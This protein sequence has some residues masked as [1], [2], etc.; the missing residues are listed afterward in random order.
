LTVG[1]ITT[2]L[3][4]GVASGSVISQN[5]TA[6]TQV[7]PGTSVALV[8]SL[9]SPVSVPNT[10]NLTQTAAT[11]AIT[12]AHLVVGTVSNASSATVPA[13]SVISQNPAAGTQVQSGSAVALVISSGPPVVPPAVDKTISSDGSGKRTTSSFST[14]SANE[15]LVAF[16]A[17]DGPTSGAS[18]SPFPEPA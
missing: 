5:P 15:V 14:S 8:V 4:S 12:G 13:G 7:T 2:A 18:R 10:V 6:G 1:I 16:A 11:T 17:S 3:N 9:G